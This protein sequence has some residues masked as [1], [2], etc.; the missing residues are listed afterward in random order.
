MLSA[1]TIDYNHIGKQ[2]PQCMRDVLK[3]KGLL[4]CKLLCFCFCPDRFN[5]VF[6]T[7]RGLEWET[8][9][10]NGGMIRKEGHK[11]DSL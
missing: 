8:I 9:V 10:Y 3:E 11:T 2:F 6:I 7:F 4:W 5:Y 1:T